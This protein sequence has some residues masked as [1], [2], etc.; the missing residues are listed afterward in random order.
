MTHQFFDSMAGLIYCV[1]VNISNW[2]VSS[3][4]RHC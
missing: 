1:I 3:A 4:V 2:G